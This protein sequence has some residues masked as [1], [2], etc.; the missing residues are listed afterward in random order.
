M[1][2]HG[3][4]SLI[5]VCR[6]DMKHSSTSF[7][8]SSVPKISIKSI[9]WNTSTLLL[10]CQKRRGKEREAK[11]ER[12]EKSPWP[13]TC[14]NLLRGFK[15][16]HF[17]CGQPFLLLHITPFMWSLYRLLYFTLVPEMTVRHVCP[18]LSQK[19]GSA[20]CALYREPEWFTGFSYMSEGNCIK[21][22]FSS[23]WTNSDYIP[24][25]HRKSF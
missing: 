9:T 25:Q 24:G 17:C 8:I 10:P 6:S 5:F 23:W 11:S 16:M 20:F 13:K 19:K 2:C 21:T 15:F 7:G 1:M 3:R 22:L 4:T 12:E 18:S 14:W